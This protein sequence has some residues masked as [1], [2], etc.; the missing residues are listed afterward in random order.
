L[1]PLAA[2]T[3]AAPK[4]PLQIQRIKEEGGASCLPPYGVKIRLSIGPEH[5]L[6]L[7]AYHCGVQSIRIVAEPKM[8]E[9]GSGRV[10]QNR[11]RGESVFHIYLG[12]MQSKPKH[13]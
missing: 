7:E 10:E 13:Q 6:N 8:S 4:R 3:I 2:L 12:E 1:R 9:I 5:R 11:D